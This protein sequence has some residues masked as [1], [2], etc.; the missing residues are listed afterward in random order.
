MTSL[1]PSSFV[2]QFYVYF[3]YP[4]SGSIFIKVLI[5]STDT[6]LAYNDVKENMVSMIS[7]ARVRAYARSNPARD[8]FSF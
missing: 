1:K 2:L 4:S 6:I 7:S 3:L 8:G 5:L